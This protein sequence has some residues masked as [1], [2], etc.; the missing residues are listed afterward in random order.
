M[1]EKKSC[2]SCR[3][4]HMLKVKRPCRCDQCKGHSEWQ[5]IGPGGNQSVQY[6]PHPDGEK[7]CKNCYYEGVT[8]S[9][10]RYCDPKNKSAKWCK[11]RGYSDWSPRPDGEKP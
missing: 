4:E 1:S 11:E 7:S 9:G 3:F 5:G 8:P 10:I 2:R 6:H